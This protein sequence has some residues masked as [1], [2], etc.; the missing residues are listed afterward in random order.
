[1]LLYGLLITI[2]GMLAVFGFLYLLMLTVD[3]TSKIVQ[4]MQKSNDTDKI[5]AVIAVALKQGGK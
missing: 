1:M 2:I 3:I 5:V 4:K